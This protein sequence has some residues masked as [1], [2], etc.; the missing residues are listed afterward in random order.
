MAQEAVFNAHWKKGF[1]T[2]AIGQAVS[3][4]GSSAVQFALIWYLASSTNSPLMLSFAG[5]LAFLPQLLLG[6]FVGVWID[7]L[8]R[9]AV[10]ICS[11]MFIGL[12]AGVFA[13]LFVLASPPFWSV[14]VVLGVRAVGGV[15]H[16]PAI[17]AA[18]PRLVPPGELVRANGWSQFMQSGAFMLGPVIGAAMYAM[19]PLPLI[20]LTDLLGALVACGTVAVVKIPEIQRQTEKAPH[21]L[22]ELKEGVKV[23]LAHKKL[24]V[25]ILVSTVCMIFILPVATL[26]P[27]MSSSYFHTTPWHASLVEIAYA[28]GMMLTAMLFGLKGDIKNKFFVM[29]LGLMTMGVCSLLNGLL[30]PSM[31]G[32]W[33]FAVLCA[34]TGASGN[35]YNIPCVAYLQQHIPH[36][37]QGRAFSLLSSLMSLAMPLGLMIAGPV[38]ERYGVPMWF[39][40]TGIAICVLTALCAALVKLVR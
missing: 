23:Y 12:V 35:I 5:L 3:L 33:A 21:F 39:F 27:L 40:I 37:A 29:H 13:L 15:F 14:C 24:C 22:S 36:E 9:K 38:A 32:F 16:S 20:L 2:I 19:L 8:P 11:D 25:V 18:I 7:R 4:I 28:G 31:G 10:I 26:Y 34:L 30:P 1:F 17:Q 6:P